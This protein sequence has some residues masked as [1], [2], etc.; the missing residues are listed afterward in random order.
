MAV[1]AK[2][3]KIAILGGGIGALATAFEL[4]SQEDWQERFDITIHQMGWRLGGKCASS[5]GVNDRI[6]EHGVHAFMGSYYN[7]LPLMAACYAKLGRPPGAPLATFDEAF[8]HSNFGVL[9]ERRNN[10]LSSWTQTFPTNG[11]SPKARPPSGSPFERAIAAVIEMFHTMLVQYSPK[12]FSIQAIVKVVV[13]HRLRKASI[14]LKR[15]QALGPHHPL[16]GLIDRG[17]C[18]INRPLYWLFARDDEM[19]RL[20]FL[21]DHVLTMVSGA[22]RENVAVDGYDKLDEENWSDWLARHGAHPR[23]IASPLALNVLNMTFQYPNGDTSVPPVMGAGCYLHW[24]LKSVDYLHSFVWHFAAGTGET[25]VAPLYLVL[26]DRGVKFEF[27]HKVEALRLSD[28]GKSVASVEIAVQATVKN[29]TDYDPLIPVKGLLC[30]PSTPRH[31]QLDEGPGM[32]AEEPADLE[33]YWTG[34]PARQSLITLAAG[35]HYDT[36][37]F[38]ISLGAV[39]HLCQEL[40]AANPAWAQMVTNIKTV[41]TQA[42]QIWLYPSRGELGC[43]IRV[44]R[45]DVIF[46]TTYVAPTDG[47]AEFSKL[48][49]WENWPAPS[50]K[51]LWYFCGPLKS[52]PAPPIFANRAYPRQQSNRVKDGSIDYLRTALGALLPNAASPTGDSAGFDFRMLADSGKGPGDGAARFESQFWRANIEPTERYVTSPPGSTKYRLKA[53]ESGFDNLVIAG[54]WIYTG[55][56]V[57]SFECAVMSGKLAAH[58]VTKAATGIG[59]PPLHAIVDYQQS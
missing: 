29:G 40:M 11:K 6:E 13:K 21:V 31:E 3:Q 43:P 58:A 52:D 19:R 18:W 16:V 44:P 56:N 5:R 46:S 34:G 37:V 12:L 14:Y 23:T 1:Q 15:N 57:G 54:D 24:S 8:L 22:L 51:S 9:W 39:P 26:K 20:F 59:T 55:I 50:P 27:F 47:L 17:W 49:C 42:V 7:A 41:A 10:A 48:I 35:D 45:D 32:M 4:T 36:L 30:W 38:A 25:V 2:P 53:W 28:D 33:S